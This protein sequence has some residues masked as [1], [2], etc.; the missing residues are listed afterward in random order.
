MCRCMFFYKLQIGNKF[1]PSNQSRIQNNT[2]TLCSN[3]SS[4]KV[5][6][7]VNQKENAKDAAHDEFIYSKCKIFEMDFTVCLIYGFKS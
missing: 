7:N 2:V 5:Q 6:Y 3:N 1:P 4:S